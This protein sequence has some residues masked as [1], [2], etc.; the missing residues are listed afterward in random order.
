[1]R[2]R[3]NLY[4]KGQ[5]ISTEM[6]DDV[7]QTFAARYAETAVLTGHAERAEVRK[8][9]GELVYQHPKRTS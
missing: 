6:L 2:Y 9:T 8:L 5:L 4:E 1:M 3:I 7:T